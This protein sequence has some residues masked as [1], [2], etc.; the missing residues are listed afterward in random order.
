MKITSVRTT[1]LKGTDP[2]G[3]DGSPRTWHTILVRVDTD[4]GLYGLGE[5]P[6]WQR[7]TFGVRD[8]IH[9]LGERVTGQSPFDIRRIVTEHLHGARPPLRQVLVEYLFTIAVR[10]PLYA[11]LDFRMIL[12]QSDDLI[13]YSHRCRLNGRLAEIEQDTSCYYFPLCLQTIIQLYSTFSYPNVLYQSWITFSCAMA[14][15]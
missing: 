5:A 6:H 3:M 12:Q 7:D 13:D 1:V 14:E 15:R 2:A 9:Y 10:M 8:T 11:E 4:E